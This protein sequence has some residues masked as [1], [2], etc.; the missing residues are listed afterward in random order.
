MMKRFLALL[1]FSMYAV[2][3]GATDLPAAKKLYYT[4]GA[5]SLASR[6]VA[7]ELGLKLEYESV[8]LA[9][10]KTQSKKDFYTINKKGAVPALELANGEILTEG[11]VIMQYLSDSNGFKLLE[12]TDDFN[13][14]RTLEAVNYISTELHKSI[15]MLFAFK[16]SDAAMPKTIVEKKLSQLNKMLEGNKSGFFIG[17]KF[18]IADA[19]LATVLR[20][21]AMFGMDISKYS[22]IA[23]Y[24][25]NIL[26]RPSVKKSLSA[27]C[28][29]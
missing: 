28:L 11:A 15:A 21:P 6:I 5:C 25:K 3:A 9:T 12:K 17:D 29:I 4:K 26:D 16:G 13:R 19:Y 14:Y 18:T 8:D 7:N 27:E 2:S 24:H 10:H 22:N 1:V 20:W 23:T